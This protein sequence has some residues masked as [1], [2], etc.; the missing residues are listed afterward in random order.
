MGG[1]ETHY[2]EG[3]Q[4]ANVHF[5]FFKSFFLLL[6]QT[7]DGRC[8]NR[9]ADVFITAFCESSFSFTF[10]PSFKSFSFL[11]GKKRRKIKNLKHKYQ[12]HI[13]KRII[14]HFKVIVLICRIIISKLNVSFWNN[15]ILGNFI[16]LFF[17]RLHFA[18][19][20]SSN[21]LLNRERVE[22]SNFKCRKSAKL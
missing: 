6:Q 8:L 11:H 18:T 20:F 2:A 16:S 14:W 7:K 3:E 5:S 21:Q 17:L 15:Y 10:P 9:L 22:R 19:C 4:V 1:K 13:L 12:K